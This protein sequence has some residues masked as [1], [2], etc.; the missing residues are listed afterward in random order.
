MS[1]AG[2]SLLGIGVTT[3]VEGLVMIIGGILIGCALN[4]TRKNIEAMKKILNDMKTILA[5]N[6]QEKEDSDMKSLM[7]KMNERIEKMEQGTETLEKG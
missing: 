1:T 5:Q 3:L 4:W 7:K 2:G 6:K